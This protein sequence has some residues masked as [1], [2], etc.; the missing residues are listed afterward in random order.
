MPTPIPQDSYYLGDW[1]TSEVWQDDWFGTASPVGDRH[2]ISTGRWAYTEIIQDYT[3][4][5]YGSIRNPYVQ[6]SNASHI[7]VS[8]HSSSRPQP[9]LPSTHPAPPPARPSNILQVWTA[10][11]TLEHQSCTVRPAISLRFRQ[12][13]RRLDSAQLC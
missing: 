10:A 7:C 2:A 5:T 11:V 9:S 12:E 4:S 3:D 13:G 1:T 6:M 8:G